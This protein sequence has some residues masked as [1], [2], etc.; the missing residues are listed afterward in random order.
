MGPL[1]FVD[2]PVGW[3]AAK[4]IV[5]MF[6]LRAAAMS[7]VGGAIGQGLGNFLEIKYERKSRLLRQTL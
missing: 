5:A 1:S 7:G 2:V 6:A 3:L 4:I